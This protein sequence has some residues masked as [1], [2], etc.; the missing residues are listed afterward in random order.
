[1]IEQF[2]VAITQYQP[3][4]LTTWQA[5]E[6]CY[7]SLFKEAQRQSA[8]FILLPEYAGLEFTALFP[9]HNTLQQFHALQKILPEYIAMCQRLVR[10]YGIYFQPGTI[11][12]IDANGIFFNR[13]Y[14]FGPSGQYDYQDKINLTTFE[15]SSQLIQSGNTLKIFQTTLMNIAIAV[16][17]D[18]EFPMLVQ[19]L[20][21]AG[22]ELILVPSCTDSMAGYHRISCAC[23]ARALENQCFV[24]NACLV[25][26]SSWCAFIDNNIGNAGVYSPIDIGFP[27]DGV[28]AHGES[29][30]FELL[31]VN[32]D[33]RKIDRVRR[34]GAV[35]NYQ[36][37]RSY[38]PLTLGHS[39]VL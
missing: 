8:N 28:L 1:M 3:Q 10:T 22:A 12:A 38:Q 26:K 31:V 14:F 19:Q 4:Q 11:P 29:G 27:E 20:V 2:R 5:Y 35:R 37:M 23:R 21:L 33:R 18:S 30:A 25:G 32:I 17:Y 9:G 34:H 36:D 13:A 39:I 6:D 7:D 16:C 15:R 24:A